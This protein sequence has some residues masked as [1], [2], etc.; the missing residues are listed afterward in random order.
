MLVPTSPAPM[1]T[2]YMGTTSYRALKFV[3]IASGAAGRSKE[4]CPPRGHT[5]GWVPYESPPR[6][7]SPAPEN[8][9]GSDHASR[10]ETVRCGKGIEMSSS[11]NRALTAFT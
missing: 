11:S 6:P 7:D 4:S 1:T 5:E 8:D 3:T 9:D 10:P 2:T